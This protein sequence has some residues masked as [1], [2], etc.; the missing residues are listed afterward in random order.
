MRE[1]AA[2]IKSSGFGWVFQHYLYTRVC[3][4]EAGM[5]SSCLFPILRTCVHFHLPVTIGVPRL[6]DAIL[7]L[8]A[9]L[10]VVR[11]C[12]RPR[13]KTLAYGLGAMNAFRIRPRI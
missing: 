10:L 3:I 4:Y 8:G 11:N 13:R 2:L 12:H 1:K 9:C 7:A 5:R 6:I